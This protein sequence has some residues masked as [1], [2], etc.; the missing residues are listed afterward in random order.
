MS[1]QPMSR[2]ESVV[3]RQAKHRFKIKSAL[4]TPSRATLQFLPALHQPKA[5]QETL[6]HGIHTLHLLTP[7][8]RGPD[9]TL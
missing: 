7:S 4:G 2:T 6:G 8:R 5:K 9:R 1:S 3:K